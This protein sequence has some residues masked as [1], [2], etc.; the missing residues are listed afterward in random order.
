MVV[1]QTGAP[2]P[3]M[4]GLS[5]HFWPS[6]PWP[7]PT[8]RPSHSAVVPGWQR[9]D[10]R[11]EPAGWSPYSVRHSCI[12]FWSRGAG[13]D[14]ESAAHAN[15]QPCLQTASSLASQVHVSVEGSQTGAPVPQMVRLPQ[16]FWPSRPWPKPTHW[17]AQTSPSAR[18][19]PGAVSWDQH[20]F[21]KHSA[22]AAA[23]HQR[24]PVLEHRLAVLNGPHNSSPL[25]GARLAGPAAPVAVRL[26]QST[27]AGWF[28]GAGL[29]GAPAAALEEQ[30]ACGGAAAAQPCERPSAGGGQHVTRAIHGGMQASSEVGTH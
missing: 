22:A 12:A 26:G 29:A 1:L 14:A 27:P 11:G 21:W 20:P 18:A 3:Q 17:P 8:H 4:A 9:A 15:A 25:T 16:H 13:S 6:R 24:V 2:V 23:C 10:G 30:R 7:K 28:G 19:V 5:Q